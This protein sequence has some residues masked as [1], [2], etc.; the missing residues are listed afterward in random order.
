VQKALSE[1]QAWVKGRGGTISALVLDPENGSG[2]AAARPDDAL[3]PASN[4]KLVTAAVALAMLGPEY[5]FVTGLY[6]DQRGSHVERL[7]LRGHGD[8]SLSMTD[9]WRLARALSH[10]G[11]TSVG[12]VLVDQTR[13]DDQFVP[14][15]F[16]Q[17]PDEWAS[18]R[19]PVSAVAIDQ[20]QLT[21]HVRPAVA[22]K[23]A[24][25]WFEPPGVALAQGEVATR[26]PG[27]GQAI[28]LDL[29]S[30]EQ[31]RLVATLGGHVAEGLPRLRFAKRLDDPRLAPARALEAALRETGVEV[32]GSVVLGGSDVKSRLVFHRS[33]PLSMLLHALGKRSD[34]FYA[35]M[36][37]KVLGAEAGQRPA[38][39]QAERQ[40]ARSQDG[41]EVVLDWLARIGARSADTRIENGSGLF[42]AN[43]ISARSLTA[44]LAHV[45]RDPGIAPE[46]LSQLSQ[47]GI[48]GTLS[49]RLRAYREQRRVRAKT[50]TLASVISLG[51]YVA[52]DAGR[53]P[54]AFAFLVNGIEGH[55]AAIRQ[56]IDRVV[57]SILDCSSD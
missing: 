31:G 55:A 2:W 36:I 1:L 20:N 48:D 52:R 14:P 28:R 23:P 50:G 41:A 6:G 51:G 19:A 7:V 46:F 15:A 56:R 40:P 25:A 47:A 13:F 38:H 3:N 34:N 45:A 29:A 16:E 43:R 26:K 24:H 42:D 53:P 54:L 11:V 35:E 49:S 12:D 21:L 30:N 18:F 5:A 44:V 32:R 57:A 9:V 17:Q 22:G 10:L 8:P 27:S 39:G 4:M 37:F 33:E